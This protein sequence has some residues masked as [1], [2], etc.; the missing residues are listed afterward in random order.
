VN[1]KSIDLIMVG[2]GPFSVGLAAEDIKR[3]LGVPYILDFRDGLTLNPYR[4]YSSRVSRFVEIFERNLLK[5]SAGLVTTTPSTTAAYLEKYHFLINRAVTVTNGFDDEVFDHLPR[6]HDP[7]QFTITYSGVIDE[8]RDIEPLIKIF[9]D[10]QLPRARLV[11]IGQ[12]NRPSTKEL[13]A[14]QPTIYYLGQRS[15]IDSLK[16]ILGANLLVLSQGFQILNTKCQPI[17]AKTFEY[18]RTGA[19]ILSIAPPGDNTD[20]IREY[21]RQPYLITE[22][23]DDKI[24]QS[25]LDCYRRWERNQITY[26]PK[27]EFLENFNR[28]HLAAKMCW[29]FN[30]V[31]NI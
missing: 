27:P 13:I 31:L 21:C 14:N 4:I 26:Q 6:S 16:Q 10:L 3:E 1:D 25:L 15:R 5:N 24:R 20:I 23:S 28:E 29:F 19:P 7:Q 17:A 9:L 2:C 12:I 18:L 11:I 22:P 8:H 30:Q